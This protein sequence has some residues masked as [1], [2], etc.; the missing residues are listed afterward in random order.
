MC[1]SNEI[2]I[3]EAPRDV[4]NIDSSKLLQKHANLSPHLEKTI[5]PS[6]DA[7]VSIII[8][9]SM[10]DIFLKTSLVFW[11]FWYKSVRAR[12]PFTWTAGHHIINHAIKAS[13]LFRNTVTL[14]ANIPAGSP[15]TQIYST[16]FMRILS[17]IRYS[18]FFIII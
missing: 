17:Q 18:T 13:L 7:K 14:Q 6:L 15:L 11:V 16:C 3:D 12:N 2:P 1:M 8:T 4:R 5:L 9:K 10:D